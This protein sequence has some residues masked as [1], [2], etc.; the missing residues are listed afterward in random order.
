M[1]GRVAFRQTKID[2]TRCDQEDRQ[3]FVFRTLHA[4][5]QGD[6]KEL[7]HL[8]F[9]QADLDCQDYDGRRPLHL[10]ASQG[11]LAC[12]KYLIEQVCALGRR[13]TGVLC[14]CLRVC[15]FVCWPRVC[16]LAACAMRVAEAAHA[17]VFDS[18]LVWCRW[19]IRFV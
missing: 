3:S 6:L 4:A 1:D 14:A 2:P 16:A 5:S 12:V 10:A 9:R 19:W 18:V 17:C 15:C 13:S 11:H 7:K 8:A